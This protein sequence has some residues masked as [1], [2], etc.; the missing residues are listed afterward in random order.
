[1]NN[2]EIMKEKLPK[3]FLENMQTQ[4]DA[5]EFALFLREYEKPFLKARGF[6]LL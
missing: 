4:L 2:G 3:K 5:D 6:F 1:M